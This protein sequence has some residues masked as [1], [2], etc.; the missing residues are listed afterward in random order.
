MYVRSLRLLSWT[1]NTVLLPKFCKTFSYLF[2][3]VGGGLLNPTSTTVPQKEQSRLNEGH[4]KMKQSTH[5]KCKNGENV[6]KNGKLNEKTNTC[7][8]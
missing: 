7:I 2:V 5:K 3:H 6:R 4:R 8:R 1:N